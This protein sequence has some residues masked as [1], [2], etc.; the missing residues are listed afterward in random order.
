MWFSSLRNLRR[1][2]KTHK[3]RRR[4]RALPAI[5][6]LEE[7]IVPSFLAPIAVDGPLSRVHLGDFN[8]DGA[9]DI[10]G[11]NP[12]GDSLEVRLG[13]GDATFQDPTIWATGPNTVAI[14][15]ADFNGDGLLDIAAG[16][17]VAVSGDGAGLTILLGGGDGRFHQSQ[18]VA[19][20]NVGVINAG[21]VNND[22]RLDLVVQ[23]TVGIGSALSVLPGNGD[24]TFGAASQISLSGL[25]TAR[26][27]LI[28]LADFNRDGNLDLMTDYSRLTG[29]Y[30]DGGTVGLD[31]RLG[32]GDGTFQ[33]RTVLG[34]GF[35]ATAVADFNN[36]GLPD[37]LTVGR[38]PGDVWVRPGNGDGSFQLPQAID[39]GGTQTDVGDFDRDGILD[40]ASIIV[41][42]TTD[43]LDSIGLLLGNGNGTFQHRQDFLADLYDRTPLD[44]ADVN[45]DG[46]SD[47]VVTNGATGGITVLLNDGHWNGGDPPPP[48][49]APTVSVGD[50]TVVEGTGT[51]A[52]ALFTVSLSSP[53]AVPVSVILATQDGTARAGRDYIAATG[54]V[55]FAPGEQTKTFAVAVM[56]DSVIETD[57]AFQVHITGVSGA[58]V[59]DATATGT[60]VDDEPALTS[61]DAAIVEGDDGLTPLTFTL[62]LSAPS[63][64]P[65]VVQYKTLSLS[66]SAGADF[67]AA[68][69]AV[70]FQPGQTVA[71]VNVDVRG[72]TYVEPNENFFLLLSNADGQEIANASPAGTIIDDDAAVPTLSISDVT[73]KE[74]RKGTTSFTFTVALS[75]PS[76]QV[77]TVHFATADGTA[78]VADNDYLSNS[79][80]LTFQPGQTSKSVTV[81]VR[82]DKKA[83]AD[84]TFFVNLSSAQNALI[85]DGQGVGTILNDDGGF[86]SLDAAYSDPG[87]LD[88][89]LTGRKRK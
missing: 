41:N 6:S 48:P 62:Q 29:G 23:N 61:Q 50:A 32:N 52:E 10:V 60:I 87:V 35:T 42:S 27:N 84:E 63:P 37:L 66:A 74:G 11:T 56:G 24:G 33:A 59:A 53:A 51:E 40:V 14:K 25:S 26:E 65:I 9:A 28:F 76:S 73:R 68:N 70:T 69:G 71:A 89:V 81:S 78:L 5:Q 13:N 31:L 67:I 1:A 15:L 19:A 36:D 45:G 58:T 88:A 30:L 39:A 86:L 7:R 8:N 18:Y 82:G 57:E 75:A 85:D 47:V 3:P 55:A 80:M 43:G 83:E 38:N 22:G 49:P 12:T 34:E 21:D 20:L 79:G 2:T 77:V 4:S 72:D 54:S 44:V 16:N 17:Y 46:Y 64:E